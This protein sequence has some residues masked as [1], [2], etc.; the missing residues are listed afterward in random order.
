MNTPYKSS[1]IDMDDKIQRLI[2]RI[3]EIDCMNE[4]EKE[5]IISIF[6]SR[7]HFLLNRNIQYAPIKI[8]NPLKKC[9]NEHEHTPTCRKLVF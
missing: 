7:I 4:I 6:T 8:G 5:K 3:A 1:M 2:V 9:S